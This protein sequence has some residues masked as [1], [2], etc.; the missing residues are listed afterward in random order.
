M[1][2][3]LAGQICQMFVPFAF[4]LQA[5]QPMLSTKRH[6]TLKLMNNV[7]SLS[8]FYPCYLYLYKCINVK[9]K[10][11]LQSYH[12]ITIWLIS[13]KYSSSKVSGGIT[14]YWNQITIRPAH[15]INTFEHPPGISSITHPEGNLWYHP[16]WS[17]FSREKSTTIHNPFCGCWQSRRK[18]VCLVG[19]RGDKTC[20]SA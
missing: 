3:S 20:S 19:T 7:F 18:D 5:C 9:H 6:F 11:S 10:F 4:T 17:N 2:T 13:Y 12:Q 16:L 14:L 1:N 8:L 15:I